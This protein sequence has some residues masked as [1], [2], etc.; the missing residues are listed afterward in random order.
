MESFY[1]PKP[2]HRRV[3]KPIDVYERRVETYKSQILEVHVDPEP[4]NPRTAYEHFS[5]MPCVH[6]RYSLGD[7]FPTIDEFRE[8]QKDG[9]VLAWLPLYLYDHSGLTMNTKGFHCP[10]DSGQVGYIYYTE[11]SLR[12]HGFKEIPEENKLLDMLRAEVEEYD[13]YLR[14]EVYGFKAYELIMIN[15]SGD[16]SQYGITDSCWNFNYSDWELMVA[17]MIEYAGFQH[18]CDDLEQWERLDI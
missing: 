13:R 10:W 17:T 8:L 6:S 18:P 2:D 5:L 3:E 4:L 11:E 16:I 14:G 15:P 1:I 9:K 7:L 12:D